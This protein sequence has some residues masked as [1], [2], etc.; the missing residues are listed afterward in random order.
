[1]AL[2]VDSAWLDD[3][4][5]VCRDFPVTG[6]TT[7]P[8]IVLAAVERGQKLTLDQL[9]RELLNVCPGQVFLQPVADTADELVAAGR[10]CLAVDPHRIVLK[11]P[12]TSDGLRAGHCAFTPAE[13]VTAFETLIQRVDTGRWGGST[14]PALLNQEALSLGTGLNIAPPAFLNFS[15]APFPR[16]FDARNLS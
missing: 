10:A 12:M 5:Q 15:P 1:M 14:N 3:V 11:L 2:L 8:T 13:T 6:V 9:A 4:A 7:N 16:P